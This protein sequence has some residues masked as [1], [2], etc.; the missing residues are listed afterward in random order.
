MRSFPILC[1]RNTSKKVLAMRKQVELSSAKSSKGLQQSIALIGMP[2]L[3]TG[4]LAIAPRQL[5]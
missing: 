1:L 4:A 3:H 5:G 2:L